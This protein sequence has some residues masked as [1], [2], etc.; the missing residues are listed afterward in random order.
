MKTRKDLCLYLMPKRSC[1]ANSS[2]WYSRKSM[3]REN[4]AK[5]LNRIKMVEEIIIANI[6]DLHKLKM[7]EYLGNALNCVEFKLSK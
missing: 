5:I 3:T 4:L 1:V 2:T 7:N 6:N